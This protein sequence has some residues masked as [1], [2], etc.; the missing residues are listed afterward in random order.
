ML[1][2]GGKPFIFLRNDKDGFVTQIRKYRH[3]ISELSRFFKDLH[4]ERRRE[5]SQAA[6][7]SDEADARTLAA[8]T[9]RPNDTATAGDQSMGTK[10]G[11]LSGKN[12]SCTHMAGEQRV[13]KSSK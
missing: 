9:S 4:R 5:I 2:K 1:F 13:K 12:T 11:Y 6:G 3:E 10:T 8:S 7:A